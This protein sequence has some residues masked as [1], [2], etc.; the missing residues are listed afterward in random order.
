MAHPRSPSYPTMPLYTPTDDEDQKREIESKWNPEQILHDL[1]VVA[2]TTYDFQ[3]D[4]YIRCPY[5][6]DS[7]AHCSVHKQQGIFRCLSAKCGEHGD[8]WKLLQRLTAKN[9]GQVVIDIGRRPEIEVGQPKMERNARDAEER[10]QL[11]L[12]A[13]VKFT[14]EALLLDADAL[15]FLYERGI[16]EETI[17]A[18]KWGYA[19]PDA[20]I[21]RSSLYGPEDLI[22][23]GL[24][25]EGRRGMRRTF[26]NR[27][28]LPIVV[29]RKIVDIQARTISPDV[30][31]KYM[32]LPSR[33]KN[34]WGVKNLQPGGTT[35]VC[36]GIF[37]AALSTQ[38][39]VPAVAI[40]GGDQTHMGWLDILPDT[41]CLALAF[42]G[43]KAGHY[44]TERVGR[45][46]M[47]S[48]HVVKVVELPEGHDPAALIKVLLDNS[49]NEGAGA[50]WQDMVDSAS[51]FPVWLAGRIPKVELADP[52]KR[53]KAIEPVVALLR[54][55]GPIYR[56]Q[57]LEALAGVL[58]I[59]KRLL[60]MHL[61]ATGAVGRK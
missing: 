40:L 9:F 51:D 7:E 35:V 25:S 10:A 60:S 13:Y 4:I 23:A 11:A 57:V 21:P 61:G 28:T 39:G 8:F 26:F 41:S 29:D 27:V 59:E 19:A 54:K 30:E 33:Q 2:R 18:H 5:H 52:F 55:H 37:D 15:D 36:E 46:F 48:G 44:T 14:H 3:K 50:V 38:V 42:D 34:L 32:N 20:P 49:D 31:P 58:G 47:H 16:T 22:R 53:Q 12:R 24:I 17:I 45:R 1:G 6:D 56:E 43:D